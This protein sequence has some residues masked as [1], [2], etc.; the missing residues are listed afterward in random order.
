MRRIS[1]SVALKCWMCGSG[2]LLPLARIKIYP[3]PSQCLR[4]FPATLR[5]RFCA[6]KAERDDYDVGL[7]NA[8]LRY[9]PLLRSLFRKYNFHS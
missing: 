7:A 8:R 9:I 6:I 3:F 2:P 5:D 1:C 4:V